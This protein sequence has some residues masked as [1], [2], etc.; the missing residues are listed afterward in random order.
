[1]YVVNLYV[2]FLTKFVYNFD[3]CDFVLLC[4]MICSLYVKMFLR[5]SFICNK[6]IT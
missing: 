2:F 3:V 5:H 1:M 4:I 6:N